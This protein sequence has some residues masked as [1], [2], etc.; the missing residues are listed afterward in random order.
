MSEYL[1]MDK[2]PEPKT[3]EKA[4]EK[5]GEISFIQTEKSEEATEQ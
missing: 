3:E 5:T 1:E 4:E 2:A